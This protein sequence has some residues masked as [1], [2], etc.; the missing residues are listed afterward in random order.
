MKIGDLLY[1][2]PGVSFNGLNFN[3][4]DIVGKFHKRI[5]AYYL[6][7]ARSFMGSK[8]GFPAMVLLVSCMDAI[9]RYASVKPLGNKVR[10]VAWLQI[11]LPQIFSKEKDAIQFYEDVRCGIVHEAVVKSG[12]VFSF[13]IGKPIF[14][15]DGIMAV[16]PQLLA[17]NVTDALNSFCK[18]VADDA[19]LLENFQKA[20]KD[21]F[22]KD[23]ENANS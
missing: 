3:S 10:Y 9:G 5:E 22:K 17:E 7:P 20:L 21:D 11:A 14:V 23:L 19:S 15:E 1:F 18:K 16:N 6:A 2:A 12:C 4:P 13:A 8:Q